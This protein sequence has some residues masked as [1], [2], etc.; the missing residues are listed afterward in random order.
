MAN[1]NATVFYDTPIPAG[2]Y[3]EGRA[4]KPDIVLWNKKD[5]TAKIIEVTVPNDYGLCRAER[6]KIAKY[7]DLQYDLRRTWSLKEINIIPVVV[8]ATGLVKTNFKK[9]LESIPGSPSA[10]EVQTAAI[11]GTV[12]ILKRALGYNAQNA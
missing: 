10:Q 4:I 3:I 5:K 7:Q 6:E 2:R 8:G 12:S 9:Y 1:E 11:K